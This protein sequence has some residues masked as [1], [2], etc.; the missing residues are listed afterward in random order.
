MSQLESRRLKLTPLKENDM[1]RIENNIVETTD[2]TIPTV[3]IEIIDETKKNVIIETKK[4]VI[5]GGFYREWIFRSVGSSST[6]LVTQGKS[7]NRVSYGGC[8]GCN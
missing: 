5:V 2:L 3:C 1:K 8:L 7:P 6:G 4:N